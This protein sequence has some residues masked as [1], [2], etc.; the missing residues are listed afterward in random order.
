[1]GEEV[2]LFGVLSRALVYDEN[3]VVRT[4]DEKRSSIGLAHR[5]HHRPSQDGADLKEVK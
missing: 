2:H 3:V 1:M 4:D 5:P